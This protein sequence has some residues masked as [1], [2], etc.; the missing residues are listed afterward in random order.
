MTKDVDLRIQGMSC[1]HCVKAAR[2]A[3]E[4][5]EGVTKVDVE[6]GRARVV[7]DDAVSRDALAAAIA[8]AGFELG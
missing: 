8:D 6:I 2:E 3:L 1:G 5:V 7:C 4:R